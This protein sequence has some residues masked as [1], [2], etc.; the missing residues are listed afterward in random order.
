MLLFPGDV[1]VGSAAEGQAFSRWLQSLPI[2]GPRVVT[3][4]NM[5]TGT[6]GR[7][8]AALVPGATV[9]V[10]TI[11]E[12]NGYR[13]FGSP[14]TPRFAGAYQLDLDEA[15]SV[16]FWSRLLPPNSD[17]DIVLTHGPPRGIADAARGVS[18]GDI[19]L[20]KAVQALEKPP[21][22]WVC[23]HIHEQYGE[24]RVPHPRAPGGILLVNSAVY[25]ATKPE[26]AA[27]VQPR[28]VALPEV[29]VV[30]QGA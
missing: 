28:V 16:A 6:R 9:I 22:L 14:W 1:E 18:R 21:L 29:K 30:A 3:W 13:I 8:A 11:Q 24:H 15:E 23:G 17:V 12:V 4:G 5:D 2:T 26:H 27:K 19:G 20:L 25:Y 7:D 10:D